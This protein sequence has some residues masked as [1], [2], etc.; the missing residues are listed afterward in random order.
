MPCCIAFWLSAGSGALCLLAGVDDL[1][2]GAPSASFTNSEL[3]GSVPV[4]DTWQGSGFREWGKVYVYTGKKGGGL[5]QNATT[6]IET[7][8]DL[9][10]LGM[11]LA[12][13]DIDED[14]SGA[15]G[16]DT[17]SY[18]DHRHSRCPAWLPRNTILYNL[19]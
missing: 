18:T 8:D 3:N 15:D 19:R 16:G 7:T 6:V 4:G 9:T 1:A 13:V 2:V 14:G 17:H 12:A 5:P 10:G 11:V